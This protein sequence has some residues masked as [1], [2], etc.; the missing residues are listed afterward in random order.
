MEGQFQ[1]RYSAFENLLGVVYLELWKNQDDDAFV[2]S[3]V[4]RFVHS[5]FATTFKTRLREKFKNFDEE[6]AKMNIKVNALEQAKRNSD[7][8]TAETIDNMSIPSEEADFA[9]DIWSV[10]VDVLTEM[11]FNIPFERRGFFDP[12]KGKKSGVGVHEGF[13]T[14]LPDMVL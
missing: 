3:R 1:P 7:A 5:F 10:I 14:R 2:V 12:S 11:G 8:L 9:W 13:P 4:Y 6:L